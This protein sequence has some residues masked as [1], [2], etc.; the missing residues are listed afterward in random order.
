MGSLSS[1]I[2]EPIEDIWNWTAT[3]PPTEISGPPQL[4]APHPYGTAV[5]LNRFLI[6]Y[7]TNL[8]GLSYDEASRLADELPIGGTM[9]Y[10]LP[11][12]V[13]EDI[14]GSL[15]R[16]LY[17]ELQHSIHGRVSIALP[18]FFIAFA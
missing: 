5:E 1:L 9:L 16:I 4:D 10:G 7:Y 6:Q 11:E 8:F 17:H 15:G 13:L 14:Y 3:K 2:L 18:M 12:S